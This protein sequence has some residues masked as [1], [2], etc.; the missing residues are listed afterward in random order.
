MQKVSVKFEQVE[1]RGKFSDNMRGM[2]ISM[3][4]E[5]V[6]TQPETLCVQTEKGWETALASSNG[7]WQL[8]DISVEI[9]GGDLRDIYVTASKTA[10]KRVVM[11]WKTQI[12]SGSL[13]LGDHWERGYGD[14]E[15]R[16]IVPDRV[17]P[18][19]FLLYDGAVTCGLGVK[20]RA[21]SMCFWQVNNDYITLVLDVRN[22][23]SGVMLAGRKLKAATLVTYSGSGQESAFKAACNFCKTL[24]D[25][26]LLPSSPIY[27]GNNWYYAYG[28]SSQEQI[29]E[30]SRLIASLS[31]LA[32][33][34]PFMVIDDGWQT[35][36]SESFNGGP[37]TCGNVK[38]PDM[39]GL[40]DKMRQIGTRPG[41][42]FRPLLTM[43]NVPDEFLLPVERF[44]SA[45]YGR[46]LDPSSEYAL[47]II[48]DDVKR[49]RSW[50]YEMIK[51]DFSTYDVFGRWGSQM[52]SELTNE[53]WHFGDRSRTTA[54]IILGL[55]DCIREAA[56][57]ALLIGCNTIG[58][59]AAGT[60][61]LQRTGDD[62]S[63]R[64]WERARKMGVNTLA[65]RMPQHGSF[66]EADADCVGVTDQIPWNLNR[67]WLHLAAN[68]GTALFVSAD[69]KSMDKQ[70]EKD[71]M[72]AFQTASQKH[73]AAE[74]LDWL[75]NTCPARWLINQQEVT[76][77][78]FEDAQ[79]CF[80]S[81]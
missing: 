26:P 42:W 58:H 75:S 56:G 62:T 53:G 13:I 3:N 17:L 23:A 33:N 47:Q 27:G 40:S 81:I 21:N 31:E 4:F 18:W 43:D 6:K 51:H 71:L 52:K 22:G 30:D 54:E 57:D 10:L 11:R 14:L 79:A 48:G 5:N 77:T 46:F 9:S 41:I 37:W 19:Y 8:R 78:W 34:K 32:E 44:T 35:L 73:P 1:K 55:Y 2:V 76:Y 67:Q 15:W 16:G 29:L 60:F 74:P 80:D 20:T 70:K 61:E 49:I 28:N 24:C 12:K 69:P 25:K 66:F 39:P 50:G 59:L 65:F 36:H 7:V 64:Q 72:K 63:G 38:Y 45:E 68:S